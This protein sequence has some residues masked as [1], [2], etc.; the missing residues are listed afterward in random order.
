MV[1][2]LWD[3]IK[4]DGPVPAAGVKKLAE[5]GIAQDG[6]DCVDENATMLEAAQLLRTRR[7]AG[8]PVVSSDNGRLVGNLSISDFR[9][10]AQEAFPSLNL[11]VKSYLFKQSQGSLS[12]ICL[13]QVGARVPCVVRRV[14]C[15][16]D[17]VTDGTRWLDCLTA[18]SQAGGSSF[19]NPQCIA[20]P[21]PFGAF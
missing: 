4:P 7:Y 21:P 17:C 3:V 14:S 13:T 10:L 8:L 19:E 16:A 6:V 2:H 1:R 15:V 18:R 11:S 9:G 20:F 12:P 5:L